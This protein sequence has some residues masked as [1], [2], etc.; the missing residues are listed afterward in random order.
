MRSR[1]DVSET[2]LT[3][4]TPKIFRSTLSKFER[5]V[6]APTAYFA[7]TSGELRHHVQQQK[8]ALSCSCQDAW[9]N[10]PV[11]QQCGALR[12]PDVQRAQQYTNTRTSRDNAA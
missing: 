11:P 12:R 2:F 8:P 3:A 1:Q 9:R 5:A 10:H 6:L 4:P 7:G